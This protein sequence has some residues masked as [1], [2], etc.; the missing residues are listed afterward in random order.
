MS[1]LSLLGSSAAAVELSLSLGLS[2]G[3][4]GS[5]S[6]GSSSSSSGSSS[7]SSSSSST[8]AADSLLL[9]L[10]QYEPSNALSIVALVAFSLLSLTLFWL[11]LRSRAW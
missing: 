7:S 5:S 6:S 1:T 10:F 2:L 9:R 11:L 3:S 8:G 4:S